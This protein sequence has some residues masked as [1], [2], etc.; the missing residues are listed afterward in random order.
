MGKNGGYRNVED[1]LYVVSHHEGIIDSKRWLS[2]QKQLDANRSKAPNI[3]TSHSALLSGL[4]RYA[5]CESYMRVAYGQ[6]NANIGKKRF[7]YMCSLKHNSGKTRC[8]NRNI[9]GFDLD[10]A[11]IEKLKELSINKDLLIKYVENY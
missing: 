10:T 3:G 5:K 6:F 7:Y 2:A 1:W 9:N 8:T 11:V 4:I